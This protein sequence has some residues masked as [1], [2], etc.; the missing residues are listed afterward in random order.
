MQRIQRAKSILM[1][2][3]GLTEDGSAIETIRTQAMSKRVSMEEMAAAIINANELLQLPSER[4]INFSLS[5][6]RDA[7]RH[8]C[9][10]I[11]VAGLAPAR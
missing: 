10:T 4:C 1:E 3:Q 6:K 7:A 2:R 9:R 11:D 8:R 5:R